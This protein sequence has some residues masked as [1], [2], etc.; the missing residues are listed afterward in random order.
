MSE[1]IIILLL[2]MAAWSGWWIAMR[3]E[4]RDLRLN[5]SRSAYFE[6]LT[7]LLNDQSDRAVDS[8]LAMPEM[9]RH[10]LDNQLILG[11][12]FR[13]RGELDRALHLHQQL[14]DLPNLEEGHK[15]KV[16]FALAE[17]Y[18]AAGMYHQAQQIFESLLEGNRQKKDVLTAL[19]QIYERTKQ[20]QKAIEVSQAWQNEGFG[21]REKE[22]AQYYCELASLSLGKEQ[23]I[24]AKQYLERALECDHGCVRAY[25]MKAQL[26]S[27]AG[28]NVSA[29]HCYQAIAEQARQF[30][31]DILPAMSECYQAIQQEEEFKTWMLDIEHTHQKSRITLA[32][33]QALKE[34]YPTQ[35]QEL[36]NQRLKEGKNP[37][38]LSAY[39][40][41]HYQEGNLE[42][43]LGKA[44]APKTVYQCGECGFRQQHLLWRCAACYAWDSFRPV[45][46][47]RLEER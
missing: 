28:E 14:S 15:F 37:L 29:I 23:K 45:I 5:K 20:W 25:W 30:I 16:R 19:W 18:E 1:W 24:K 27:L 34:R 31:P 7:F 32:T 26:F 33:L 22:I 12:L 35:A 2:P 17:D 42:Y 4:A 47:L 9:E 44:I 21:M 39:L 46:E 11:T 6:G 3:K 40:Q 8:F 36:L 10:V 38:L 43:A 13:K 41:E